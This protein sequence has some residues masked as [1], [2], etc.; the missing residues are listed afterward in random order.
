M[1][2][3]QDRRLTVVSSINKPIESLEQASIA[4]HRFGLQLEIKPGISGEESVE[5]DNL[6]QYVNRLEE[7]SRRSYSS[8]FYG[9]IT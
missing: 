4:D 8:E 1:E 6:K 2:S 7:K 5:L 9:E 3:I